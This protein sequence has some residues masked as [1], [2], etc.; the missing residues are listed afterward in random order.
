MAESTRKLEIIPDAKASYPTCHEQQR[1]EE[2]DTPRLSPPTME[3]IA[4]QVNLTR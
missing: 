4:H 1:N 3:E 2:R